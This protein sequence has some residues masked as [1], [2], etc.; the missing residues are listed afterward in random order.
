[1]I[2]HNCL[3]TLRGYK[4]SPEKSGLFVTG[5]IGMSNMYAQT[6][7]KYLVRMR[8]D[9]GNGISTI[10]LLWPRA[11]I[12]PPEVDFYEDGGGDRANMTATLH[13]G[14]NGVDNCK[15]QKSLNGYDF[16]QWHTVGVEWTVG[17]LVY[18]IDGYRWAIVTGPGV[19]SIPMVLGL[20]SQ[21]LECSQYNT[22][23]IFNPC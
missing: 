20:Q 14:P 5:G 10:A 3:L 22:C 21:S 6:Y 11:N 18:T 15:I 13:C 2:V 1:M 12:W 4:D 17:K 16:S 8:A 9:R 7:G 23:L 19:P